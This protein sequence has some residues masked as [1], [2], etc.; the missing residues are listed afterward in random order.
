LKDEGGGKKP[1]GEQANPEAHVVNL[2]ARTADGGRRGGE[3]GCAPAGFRRQ[4]VTYTRLKLRNKPGNPDAT[5]TAGSGRFRVIS[6]DQK[7]TQA[8]C[9]GGDHR[10]AGDIYRCEPKQPARQRRQSMRHGPRQW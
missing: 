4:A 9:D 7:G 1:R 6:G 8:I 3:S 2:P 10:D 5:L